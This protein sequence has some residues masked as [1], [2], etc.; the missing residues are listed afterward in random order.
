M[1]L[2]YKQD[3]NELSS[4]EGSDMYLQFNLGL[5]DVS[6][7]LVDGDFHWSQT[8]LTISSNSM[9][10]ANISFLPVI[11]KCGVILKLQQVTV[12]LTMFFSPYDMI[13]YFVF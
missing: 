11:N 1:F 8:P 9:E 10:P 5:S 12:A 4:D 3:D 2:T 7:F 6:A 13:L